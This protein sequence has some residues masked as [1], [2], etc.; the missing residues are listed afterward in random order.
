MVVLL[1]SNTRPEL[2][3]V[4]GEV[5]LVTQP[6]LE[7]R[8]IPRYVRIKYGLCSRFCD[9]LRVWE[10]MGRQWILQMIGLSTREAWNWVRFDK[11][12]RIFKVI[13]Q[14]A[15]M[16]CMTTATKASKIMQVKASSAG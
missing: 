9:W 1:G 16:I 3:N 5:H 12:M 10:R 11:V 2:S 7:L 13:M 8:Q 4:P 14:D 15:Y 6:C